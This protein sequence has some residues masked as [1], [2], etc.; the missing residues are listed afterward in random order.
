MGS[1][2]QHERAQALQVFEAEDSLLDRKKG[3]NKLTEAKSELKQLEEDFEN[4]KVDLQRLVEAQSSIE[5]K[6]MQYRDDIT[7][8]K[9]VF[10]LKLKARNL[11]ITNDNGKSSDP[12]V[13]ITSHTSEASWHTTTKSANLQPDWTTESCFLSLCEEK[14]RRKLTDIFLHLEVRDVDRQYMLQ[15]K[16]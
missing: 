1:L 15:K 5:Q 16:I 12:S 3:V 4:W 10:Q 14:D 9:K 7:T 2:V 11:L 6:R 13:K 8:G